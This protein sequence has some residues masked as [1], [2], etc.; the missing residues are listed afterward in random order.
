MR[1]ASTSAR[2]GSA[3]LASRLRVAV[4]RA[5]RR[6]RRES[7][8]GLSPTLNAALFTIDTHG[9]ITAGQLADHEQ[10][11]KPT[12][13]R[14]IAALVDLGLASRT[15]DPLDGRVTWLQTTPEGKQLLQRSR[16]RTD[17]FLAQRL[18]RLTPE[19][20]AVLHEAVELLERLSGGEQP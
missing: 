18:K 9:P 20:R 4:W 12:M 2:T 16:R 19:E 1:P 6:M 15:P 13:T 3:E 5:A 7:A 11:R 10:V 8:P 17:E 14:T